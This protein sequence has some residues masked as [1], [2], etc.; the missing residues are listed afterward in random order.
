[1]IRSNIRSRPAG[2]KERKKKWIRVHFNSM[3]TC[4]CFFLADYQM[5]ESGY[6]SSSGHFRVRPTIYANGVD[7]D[8]PVHRVTAGDR[9]LRKTAHGE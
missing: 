5:K 6:E 1:M 8:E 2:K 7:E 4:F 9:L 3:R